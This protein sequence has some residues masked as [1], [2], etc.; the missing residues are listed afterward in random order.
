MIKLVGTYRR[1]NAPIKVIVRPKGEHHPHGLDNA[2][3]IVPYIKNAAL[4]TPDLSRKLKVACVGNSI[5]E[6]GGT[7]DPATKAYPAVLQRLLGDGFEVRNFGVSCSTAFRKG[8]DSG[9]LFAWLDTDKCREAVAFAPDIVV[10]KL[11]GNDSKPDNRKYAD[12]F[13]DNYHEIIDSFKYLPTLPQIYICLPAKAR[14]DDP[15]QIWGINEQVIIEEITPRIAKIAHDNRLPA[16]NLHDVYQGEENS[17]HS[18]NIHPTDRGAEL[19]AHRIFE[20]LKT[21]DGR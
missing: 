10:I 15:D 19:I 20:A 12:E 14:V 3:A 6:G 8:T 21:H 5:T 11:G 17:C 4:A 9:R 16:I 2:A 7:S 13:D 1:Y 18:D